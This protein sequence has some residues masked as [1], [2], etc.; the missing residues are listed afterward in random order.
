MKHSLTFVQASSWLDWQ[1]VVLMQGDNFIGIEG[2]SWAEQQLY[3]E[4]LG[5]VYWHPAM[6]TYCENIAMI[7]GV[8]HSAVTAYML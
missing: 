7:S 6:D 8:E 4:P 3:P 2:S 5:A 1:C